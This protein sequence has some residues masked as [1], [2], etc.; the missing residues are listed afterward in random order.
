VRARLTLGLAVGVA[1]LALAGPSRAQLVDET[2]YESTLGTIRIGYIHETVGMETDGT[3]ATEVDAELM[4]RRAGDLVR[5]QAKE[6]WS[7]TPDGTPVA[8]HG[9][10]QLSDEATELDVTVRGGALVVRRAV[11]GEA[12]VSTIESGAG[13]LFPRGV[14]ALH[15][16]RGF[17][18][19]D[20]YGFAY[21]DTDF[22]RIGQAEVTVVGPESLTV[23]GEARTLTRL[24][25]RSDLLADI[26]TVEWRDADGRLWRSEMPLAGIAQER[27]TRE[28]ALGDGAPAAD[29]LPW[30][31]IPSDVRIEAPRGV[32]RAVYEVW[33]DG[34][35]AS[36]LIPEDARQVF[37]G[38]T[39]RGVLL[40]VRTVV[41]E[42]GSTAKGPVTSPGMEPYLEGNSLMQT[43]YP[44]LIAAAAK[45][46][47]ASGGDTWLGARQISEF[48]NAHVEDKGFGTA[49][50]SATEVLS[51]RAGDCSEHAVLMAAMTRAVGIP[52]KLVSGLVYHE[53]GFAYHMW[54]EVWTGGG[55]YA[56]DPTIG[57]GEVDATH[58]KLSES[59]A[60]DGVVADLS[61]GVLRSWHRLNVHVVDYSSAG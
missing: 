17:V 18:P 44:I 6:R 27:T 29:I 42:P 43:W 61:L 41:P 53:G 5:M 3:V 57:G 20:T 48:V 46:V 1:A 40:E 58:I 34:G 15:V 39:A 32:N 45:C 52:S 4:M 7:E 21:F 19:G 13:V 31:V 2:W 11:R 50:G 49:F 51:S 24:V 59:A 36:S 8:Y 28:I 9:R 26:D 54:V 30:T 25:V 37:Q 23:L 14:A 35:D 55:W 47:R 56:L 16:A 22:E 60:Q 12:A 38:K 33:V 10:R